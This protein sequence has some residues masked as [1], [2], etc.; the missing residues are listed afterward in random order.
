MPVI[1]VFGAFV[2][3][4]ERDQGQSKLT[5]CRV[6]LR[7]PEEQKLGR[8][9]LVGTPGLTLAS[10]PD[11]SPC[12][13]LA[14]SQNRLFSAHA[15]GKIYAGVEAAAS[16]LPVGPASVTVDPTTPV[17][18]MVEDRSA[19]GGG[20]GVCIA[21]NGSAGG[22]H[23]SGYHGTYGAGTTL[24]NGNFQAT[25]QFDPTSVCILDN[26][27]VWGGG[28][29]ALQLG[30]GDRMYSSDPANSL[31]V[32]ANSWA[33]AEARADTLLDVLTLGRILWVFGSRTIEMWY[34]PGGNIDFAFSSYQNSLIEVGLAARRTLASLHGKAMWVGTDRR[35]W[36]GAGQSGQPI[37]PAW[38]DLL[39]Q[40]IDVSRLTAFMYSQGGDEFYV[41]TLEGSWSLELSISTMLW[42]YRRSFGRPDYA[43]RC[44]VEA[45]GGVVY[46]GLDTGH[47]CILN[48]NS[49]EEP[50]GRVDREIVTM[51]IGLEEAR[52][53]VDE[54][55][56]TS[57]MGPSAGSFTLDWSEDR[58]FN[59]KGQRS[60]TWPE[61][62][63]RRAI[64]RAMGSTRRRQFRVR[65]NGAT[66]PFT[67]DEF[68]VK[69]TQGS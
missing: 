25:L 69:V 7:K 22:G 23:G 29:D 36:I 21:S 37:S 19:S 67:L 64:A 13:A 60:M 14:L 46:I 53:T 51:W 52:H 49:A 40:Q 10:R 17:V 44:A 15:N 57:Y 20:Y 2:S 31:S 43:G 54:I 18:R 61:P 50:A 16:V 11:T 62:G 47:I 3:P 66:A 39:L 30:N 59:W 4:L 55:D 27:A 42:A 38:V 58:K 65:Y 33:T 5:N 12:I 6:I 32:Q 56:I 63:S 28:S 26:Y 41:L 45:P 68:F 8:S 9:I 1:D 35:V 48:G 34:N 24:V